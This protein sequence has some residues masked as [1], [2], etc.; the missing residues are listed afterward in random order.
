M[1]LNPTQKVSAS[2]FRASDQ[3]YGVL[4]E[5]MAAYDHAVMKNPWLAEAST[6]DVYR[7]IIIA[8][9]ERGIKVILDNHTSHAAWCCGLA[10]SNGWWNTADG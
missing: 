1:A 3:S 7:K 10:D 8:L 9:G 2:F 5:I 6:L 4:D